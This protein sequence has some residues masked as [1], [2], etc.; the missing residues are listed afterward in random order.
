MAHTGCR[1]AKGVHVVAAA[2]IGWCRV[3]CRRIQGA[4]THP[5]GGEE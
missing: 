1:K 2:K 5:A 3:Q 4:A